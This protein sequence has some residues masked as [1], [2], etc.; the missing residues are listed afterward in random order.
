MTE[1]TKDFLAASPSMLAL[2][3]TA[4]RI[5]ASDVTVLIQGESGVG[6]EVVAR[7]IHDHSAAAKAPFVKVNCAAI[8]EELLESEL[9]GHEKGAFTGALASK[10][11]RF[12][13]AGSGT[14]LLDE[15]SEMRVSL[16]AKLLGVL[17]DGG[18]MRLGGTRQI[19]CR[20]RICSTTNI[21]LEEAIEDGTF[22]ED[23]Y[24]R[25]KVI[26]LHVPPLRDRPEDTLLIAGRLLEGFAREYRR[27]ALR[28]TPPLEA[29]LLS[30]P[31]PGNVRELENLLKAA[32]VM[33][34]IDWAM[35][36]LEPRGATSR[37]SMRP[38]ARRSQARPA[39]SLRE[40]ASRAVAEAE[41]PAILQAL[42]A[43]RWN[44]RR[45]ARRLSVSY[46]TLLKKIRDY[47]IASPDESG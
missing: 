39:E 4:R 44:R 9:F 19:R 38:L 13:M 40:V 2:L 45:A 43:E 8:P 35:E 14:M 27:P 24:F 33:G 46:K 7:Y 28:L 29:R 6:K 15:I 23:L 5:A 41:R 10:P 47:R 42:E 30:H 22:R 17:Q 37:S 11:G 3:R 32:A 36:Q 18:F 1:V 21:S 25:L 31:W 34:D 12:E 16:Q 26:D 20:A